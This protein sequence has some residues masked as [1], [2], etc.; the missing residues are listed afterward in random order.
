MQHYGNIEQSSNEH[1]ELV[2]LLS[3][4][5]KQCLQLHGLLL[6]LADAPHHLEILGRDL[7]D[8]Y[9]IL[10]T[11]YTLSNDDETPSHFIE[12][13]K[14]GNLKSVINDCLLIFV[15]LSTIL[16]R[17]QMGIMISDQDRQHQNSANQWSEISRLH[18][19]R[20]Y[21][22]SSNFLLCPGFKL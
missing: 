22:R 16:V 11:L 7:H 19:N 13:A 6:E 20:T 1:T 21:F 12:A 8:S 5:Y 10:K 14:S 18:D 17:F 9:L 4:A 3:A 2:A 15:D